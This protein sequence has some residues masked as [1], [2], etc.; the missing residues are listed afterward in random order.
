[1]NPSKK[2]TLAEEL[3]EKSGLSLT[4]VPHDRIEDQPIELTVLVDWE[5]STKLVKVEIFNWQQEKGS[6]IIPF[7]VELQEIGFVTMNFGLR[8][9]WPFRGMGPVDFRV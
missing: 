5:K 8:N 6:N 4:G 3:G 2:K 7:L 1:M 9:I